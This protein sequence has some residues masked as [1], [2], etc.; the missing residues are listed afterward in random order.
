MKGPTT[1]FSWDDSTVQDQ[2]Y[3]PINI[4]VRLSARHTFYITHFQLYS[5]IMEADSSKSFP[6]DI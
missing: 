1:F 5:C 2:F 4:R 3:S 6:W